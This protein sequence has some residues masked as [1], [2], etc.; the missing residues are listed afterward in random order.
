MKQFLSTIEAAKILGVSRVTL[1]NRIKSGEIEATKV[2]RN[3]II[4]R[5]EIMNIAK[6]KGE[7]SDK[8]MTEIDK[9]VDRVVSQYGETL[10][11]LKDN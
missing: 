9:G 2:G 7:L 8:K 5:D 1:F 6:K 11:L 3:Y 4:P 10:K